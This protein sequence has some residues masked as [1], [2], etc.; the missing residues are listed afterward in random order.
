MRIKIHLSVPVCHN[1]QNRILL[2]GSSTSSLPSHIPTVSHLAWSTH[3]STTST[4]WSSKA[5]T[6]SVHS[7][8]STETSTATIK[9]T[10][11]TAET[12]TTFKSTAT[13]VTTWFWCLAAV[14]VLTPAK[15]VISTIRVGAI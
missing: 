2:I 3:R 8:S 10:T 13:T 12:T 15:V 6:S 5:T 11:T 9:A 1:L 14:A 7:T 4:G